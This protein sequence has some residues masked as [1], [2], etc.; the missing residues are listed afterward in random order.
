MIKYIKSVIWRVSKCLSYI[1]E[2]RCL[3][4]NVLGEN[5]NRATIQGVLG[6]SCGQEKEGGNDVRGEING[7][8]L[9]RR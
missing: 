1:E 6:L 8:E 4:V 5:T 2:A 7:A 3:K 9:R